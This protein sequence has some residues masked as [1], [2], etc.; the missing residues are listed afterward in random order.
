M[1]KKEWKVERDIVAATKVECDRLAT[2]IYSKEYEWLFSMTKTKDQAYHLLYNGV[3]VYSDKD[4]AL[5]TDKMSSIH[6]EAH[7]VQAVRQ[8]QD[9]RRYNYH[10]CITYVIKHK[11]N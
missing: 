10:S 1:S 5:V 9:E 8:V 7:E 6:K 11:S 3:V 4:S 2:V